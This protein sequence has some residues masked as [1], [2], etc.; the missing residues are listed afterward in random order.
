MISIE[1]RQALDDLFARNTWALD[2]YDAKAFS[3]TFT[4]DGVLGMREDH[5]GTTAIEAFV[6][7]LGKDL[8]AAWSNHHMSALIMTAESADT[9]VAQ[10]YVIRVHRL[11]T[12][13]RNNCS[14]IWSGYTN[15]RCVKRGGAWLFAERFFRA[16]EG[17]I[18][19]I[20]KKGVAA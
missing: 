19:S 11:P 8:P 20:A 13:A 18:A 16:W 7:A 5:R 10:S 9:V 1:D 3:A 2:L 6:A 15:D 14:I 12:Q 4:P 17:E